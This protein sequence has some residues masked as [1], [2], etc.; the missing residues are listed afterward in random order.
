MKKFFKSLIVIMIVVMGITGCSNA[1]G[2][3]SQD[4]SDK[5]PKDHLK[6]ITYSNLTDKESQ[7]K[8]RKALKNAGIKKENIDIFFKSVDNY[9]ETV[10]GEYLITKGFKTTKELSPTYNQA[11]MMEKWETKN[12]IFIGCN[13]RITSFSILKDIIK[14]KDTKNSDAS[15]LFQDED[16]LKNS[17]Y[18]IIED[19]DKNKFFGIFS[20]IDTKKTKDIKAHLDIVKKDWEKR[21]IS[22][23]KNSKA[24]MISVFFHSYFSKEENYLFIGHVGALVPVEKDKL[25]FIEKISFQEPYQAIIF[26]DRTQLNDYLMNKYDVEWDQSTAIPFIMENDKLMEGYRANPFKEKVSE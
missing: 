13:C 19:K 20:A 17:P 10:G 15:Q 25:L 22:F 7:N 26:D 4:K 23:N 5:K 24:S 3:S 21:G 2:S 1:E 12:P 14:V 8:V 16:A 18:P 9:N 6:T 11:D